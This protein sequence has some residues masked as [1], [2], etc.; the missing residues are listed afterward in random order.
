MNLRNL[1]SVLSLIVFMLVLVACGG[2]SQTTE[3]ATPEAK[4]QPV[5]EATALSIP[6]VTP[7]PKIFMLRDCP[8]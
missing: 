6:T 4:A 2:G 1:V 7:T 3:I 5:V 8:I